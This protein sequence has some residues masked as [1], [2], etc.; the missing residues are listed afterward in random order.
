MQKQQEN[1]KIEITNSDLKKN[2]SPV[3]ELLL[4]KCRNNKKMRKCEKKFKLKKIYTSPANEFLLHKY[5]NKKENDFFFKS[6]KIYKSI[7]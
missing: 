5:R 3:N 4:H 7:Y 6:K 1:T 2:S